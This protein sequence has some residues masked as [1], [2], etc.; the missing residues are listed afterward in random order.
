MIVFPPGQYDLC[1][2]WYDKGDW[3]QRIHLSAGE[4]RILNLTLKQNISIS[5]TLLTWDNTPHAD[6]TVQ[7]VQ[8]NGSTEM[9]QVIATTLSDEGGKYRFL[10]LKP[11]HYLVRCYTLDSYTYFGEEN[12]ENEKTGK[13]ENKSK[14]YEMGTI[15]QVECGKRL[16]NIN[17]RFAPFKKGTWRTYTYLVSIAK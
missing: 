4:Q 2:E 9:P 12:P 3:R 17:F 10:N 5:G 15:L 14:N 16:E 8:L 1:A 7:A 6:V 13:R 11:G